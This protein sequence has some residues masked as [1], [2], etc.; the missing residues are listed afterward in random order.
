MSNINATQTPEQTEI[1]TSIL[2]LN[3]LTSNPNDQIIETRSGSVGA[4]S[5]SVAHKQQNL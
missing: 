3:S 2:K 4:N 5:S 1:L